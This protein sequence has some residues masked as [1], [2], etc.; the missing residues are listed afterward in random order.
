MLQ[1]TKYCFSFLPPTHPAEEVAHHREFAIKGLF[2]WSTSFETHCFTNEHYEQRR[3]DDETT[4][5]CDCVSCRTDESFCD[6]PS[7]LRMDTTVY[8]FCTGPEGPE[9]DGE[10]ADR[11]SM[12]LILDG[13]FL[14]GN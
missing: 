12:W 4:A 2:L 14:G 3:M 11:Y 13:I 10:Q 8:Y 9:L 5:L 1:G 6:F 7:T